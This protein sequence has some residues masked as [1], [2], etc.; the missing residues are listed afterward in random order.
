MDEETKVAI[1]N[2]LASMAPLI[3]VWLEGHGDYD[4]IRK[5]RAEVD[6]RVGKDKVLGNAF[7]YMGELG[8]ANE[9]IEHS[10]LGGDSAAEVRQYAW[11]AW[12]RNISD[13]AP[14]LRENGRLKDPFGLLN[15]DFD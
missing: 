3:E 10:I 6:R 12:K 8:C 7:D 13:E 9:L 4:V 15:W 2:Q 5:A 14:E 11:E 1:S